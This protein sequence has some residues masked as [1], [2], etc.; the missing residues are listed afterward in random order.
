MLITFS[1]LDGAGKTTLIDSLKT[2]LEQQNYRVTAL[3]MYGQVSL[4]GIIRLVR[5][6]IMGSTGKAVP[7]KLKKHEISASPDFL[8]YET[9]QYGRLQMLVVNGLRKNSIKRCVFVLDLFILLVFRLYFERVKNRI[10][11]LDRYFYDFLADVAD[12]RR[13]LY[14]RTFLLIAPRPDIAIFVD[15][16]PDKAFLRKGEYT[17]A[18]LQRRRTIYMKIFQWVRNPVFIPNDDLDQTKRRIE[19]TMLEYLTAQKTERKSKAFE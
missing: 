17:V 7:E 13:W 2:A 8:G 9:I 18:H 10:F 1:G 16:S 4:Y 6:W 15:V 12:G 5:E 11:I 14:I 19:E 3:T